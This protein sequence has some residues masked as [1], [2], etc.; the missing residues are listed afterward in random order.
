MSSEIGVRNRRPSATLSCSWLLIQ[1][2]PKRLLASWTRL[3]PIR[4][5]CWGS[6]ARRQAT[7]SV[8]VSTKRRRPSKKRCGCARAIGV[9]RPACRPCRSLDRR[10]CQSARWRAIHCLGP[11]INL[12]EQVAIVSDVLPILAA[13][14]PNCCGIALIAGTGSIRIRPCCR[15]HVLNAAAVGDICWAMKGAAT[16]IGRAALRHTLRAWKRSAMASNQ[17]SQKPFAS[18]LRSEDGHRVNQTIYSGDN[19]RLRLLT[20]D[21]CCPPPP[22]RAIKRRSR[23]STGRQQNSL[24]WPLARP[25]RWS[26]GR[27]EFP[28][29]SSGGRSCELRADSGAASCRIG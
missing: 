5:V 13:G 11:S 7:R 24:S 9:C 21:T 23:Y 2:A 10:R 4:I 25:S 29:A 22:S 6:G 12:A 8:L 17:G 28:L 19:P 16:A 18:R 1:A 20:C 14:T 15:W 27:V 26:E 3:M